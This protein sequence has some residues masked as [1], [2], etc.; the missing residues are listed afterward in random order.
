LKGNSR[1]GGRTVG[2]DRAVTTPHASPVPPDVIAGPRLDLVLVTVEQLLARA[3]SDGPVPLGFDDP[4]DVLH[5]EDSPLH[6]RVP[7]VVADP[8][9]NPW[10]IRL[11]VLRETGEIVGLVNFHAP[12]DS[13]GMV[14]IGYRV[15][16]AYRRRGFATEMAR[17][18]WAYAAAHPDVRTLRATFTPDNDASRAI[19]EAAGLVAVGEQIDDEDGL[20]L[21]YEIAA[22]D[23]SPGQPA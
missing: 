14:E 10:L 16:P 5:P 19:I 11:A 7:Q 13:D 17:T 4:T 9:V 3:E 15:L 20:E 6:H 1:A 23:Y 8:S 22:R 18:L 21:V 12:P 2:D